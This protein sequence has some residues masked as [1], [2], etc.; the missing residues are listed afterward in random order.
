[1][2]N[3]RIMQQIDRLES[4]SNYE[5]AYTLCTNALSADSN[6]IDL[7]EKAAMLAKMVGKKDKCIEC[8]EKLIELKPNSQVAYY[9]L[10]DLYFETD[11]FKY[12]TMRA[13]YR[14]IERKPDAAADDLKKAIS[15]TDDQ[16]SI[17]ETRF[18]LASIYKATG[19]PEKAEDQYLLILDTE[20]NSTASLLLADIYAQKDDIDAAIS[21]LNQAHE[22][23]KDN[24][25][26]KK[27]LANLYMRVGENEKAQEYVTD[28]LSQVKVLL[29]QGKNDEAKNI[30]DSFVNKKDAQYYLLYAEYYYNTKQTEKCF[31]AIDE[32]SKLSPKHPLT[33]Q[34]R[35]LC[36]ELEGKEAKAKYNWGWYNLLK[37]QADVA[38]AEFLDSNDI[39]KTS[40]TLEQIIRIY[41][42]Q[43][44]YTTAAEFV[45]Q[46]VELE[47]KNTLAL[48]RLGEFYQS[49]GDADSA[50]EYYSRIL[51]YD[52]NNLPVLINAA[53]VA[54][55]I[56]KETD[57][58]EYYE[59]I[60]NLSRDEKEKAFAQKRLRIMNGEEDETIISKFLE[61]INKF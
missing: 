4:D 53:K 8:W 50:D 45:A 37:G 3:E 19:K 30:L 38:L 27:S 11:K 25:D 36:Y 44:D 6:N 2:N 43:K 40:E 21:T 14:I 5:E 9:E 17:I 42:A 10:Q 56:G 12:Y 52:P 7:L 58:M 35:A 29:R 48:K 33:Y 60:V 49:I 31:E 57:A 55:K 13:K 22:H 34:M 1:M 61:W 59:R 54:E 39:E 23:D 51:E 46:L 24:I 28:D 18:M 32:F 47:P 15:N 26:I 20:P 16:K 41:D